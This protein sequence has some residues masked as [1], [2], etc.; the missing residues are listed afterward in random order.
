MIQVSG[1][2]ISVGAREL[3]LMGLACQGWENWTLEPSQTGG[4]KVDPRAGISIFFILD[5]VITDY[6][7]CSVESIISISLGQKKD[8]FLLS[9]LRINGKRIT[10]SFSLSLLFICF[11][12]LL[13]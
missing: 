3:G 12:N 1:C 6:S 4:S 10:F 7:I 9:L 5:S 11:I 2:D 8:Y 13:Y